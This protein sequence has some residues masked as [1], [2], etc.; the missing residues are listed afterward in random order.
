MNLIEGLGSVNEKFDLS[1]IHYNYR[2]VRELF[3]YFC[4]FGC[5]SIFI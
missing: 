2:E 1:L 3:P 5:F 4:P